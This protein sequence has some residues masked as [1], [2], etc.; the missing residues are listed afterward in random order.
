M[1]G[2]KPKTGPRGEVVFE[3]SE[4]TVGLLYT[5]RA[6]AEAEAQLGKSAFMLVDMFGRGF[7]P[8]INDLAGLLRAGMEAY[9][10]EHAPSDK[11]VTIDDAYGVLDQVGYSFTTTQV[12]PAVSEVLFFTREKKA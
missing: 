9:R 12:M 4:G 10:L 8:A 1:G 6:L 2:E 11:A 7:Y 5:N 3:T